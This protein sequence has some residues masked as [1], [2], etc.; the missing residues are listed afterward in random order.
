[1]TNKSMA[2]TNRKPSTCLFVRV[3]KCES[4]TYCCKLA[5][6]H[7]TRVL[8]SCSDDLCTRAHWCVQLNALVESEAKKLLGHSLCI[9][10]TVKQVE[11]LNACCVYCLA[12][13][14]FLV[15]APRANFTSFTSISIF[16]RLR[17][18]TNKFFSV[19]R[20]YQFFFLFL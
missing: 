20:A 16:L 17:I 14:S 6:A 11:E 8:V 7:P 4:L 9:F 15:V 12:F 19:H 3:H 10:S 1:M 5:C 13:K 18:L 2:R